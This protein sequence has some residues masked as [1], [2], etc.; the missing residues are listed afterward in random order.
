MEALLPAEVMPQHR[1]ANHPEHT[2]YVIDA[3]C[4]NRPCDRPYAYG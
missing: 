4:D 1:G 2:V 3:E